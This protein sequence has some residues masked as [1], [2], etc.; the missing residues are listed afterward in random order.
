MSRLNWK[1][2]IYNGES[3][4]YIFCSYKMEGKTLDE[5]TGL[6]VLL[7][8]IEHKK[9]VGSLR[10]VNMRHEWLVNGWGD[11]H[12]IYKVAK[13]SY[14]DEYLKLEGEVHDSI[15]QVVRNFYGGEYFPD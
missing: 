11:S 1:D 12:N 8:G 6:F 5:I 10:L 2:P 9:L 7:T 15:Q 14:I 4:N 13:K 3:L